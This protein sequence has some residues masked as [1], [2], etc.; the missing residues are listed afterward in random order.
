MTGGKPRELH[1]EKA[2]EAID[3]QVYPEYRT[4]YKKELNKS[5]PI[6]ECDYF[7]VNYLSLNKPVKKD[8]YD[9]DSFVIYLCL[10]GTADFIYY[11]TEKE[12]LKK[13]ETILI[14]AEIA[15]LELLPDKSAAL[16]EVYI[17]GESVTD[18]TDSILDKLF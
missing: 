12:T 5:N 14:P 18:K 9:L 10:E 6:T 13:G 17:K 7:T 1:L 15:E 8:L 16:L 2:M 11:K 4:A 3:F